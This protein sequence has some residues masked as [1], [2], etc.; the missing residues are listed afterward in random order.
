MCHQ[1]KKEVVIL[2]L[3]FEKA[4]DKMEHQAM[5]KIMQAQGFENKWISW[6]NNIFSSGTSSVLLNS[7]P[8]KRFNCKRGV[9]QGDPLSPLL[10]VLAADFLQVLINKAKNMGLLKLPIPLQSDTDFPILQYADDTLI[11]MEGDPR[12]LFML[13]TVLQNFSDSTGL[14]INYGKS[15]MLPINISDS[16]LDL[17]ARTFGCAKGSL[18]FTYLGLPLGT[19]KPRIVDFLPLVNKCERRLGGITSLLNQAGR[20]Q[21]TNAVFSSLPTYYMCTLELPKAIIK[22]IDKFRKHCLWRGNRSNGT[23]QPKAAWKLLCKEKT[24]GGLGVIKLETQNQALLMKNLDKFFN[25]KDIPWVQ[26]VWEKHYKND[27]LPGQTKKGSFWWRDILKLLPK[28]KEFTTIQIKDGRTCLLWQDNWQTTQLSQAFPQAFSFAKNKFISVQKAFSTEDLTGLFNLPLSQTA[29][30]QLTEIQSIRDNT[31]LDSSSKDSWKLADN[32]THFSSK[33]AYKK[34]MGHQVIDEAYSWLWKSYCQPK[35][36]VFCW[37]L[38][39]DRLSTRNILRRKQ[40]I[41]E[42]YSCAICLTGQEETSEHLFWDCPFAQHC[43]T[44]L[45]V[46]VIQQGSTIQNFTA[47]KEQLQNQFFMAAT[48]LMCWTIWKVRNEAI[49]NQRQMSTQ[50]AKSLFFQEMKLVSYR[51]KAG[52]RHSFFQWIQSLF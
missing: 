15:Q 3:D 36:K 30:N 39:K 31:A 32:A 13:K 7:I 21:I 12:Q 17:L 8:G 19:T 37:L 47:I 2:K 9:R 20:L 44:L 22:Q 5:I 24:Q 46:E 41:L 26:M 35:H 14:K 51:V 33:K 40:M 45:Q 28:F 1:S 42:T 38:L 6:I 49:F 43:W 50:E 4:F 29:F 11:I 48:I 34:L 25:R 52:I 23:G 18:P 10:F 16:R 27:K